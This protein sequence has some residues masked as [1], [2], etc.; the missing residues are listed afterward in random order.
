MGVSGEYILQALEEI[1]AN[2]TKQEL[3][4][5]NKKAKL[6][7]EY[8]E[9]EKFDEQIASVFQNAMKS[10]VLGE[11][12]DFK[13]AEKQSLEIQ[14]KKKEFVEKNSIDLEAIKPLYSCEKC[15]DS[16]YVDGNICDCVRKRAIS[17]SYD[18]LNKDVDLSRYTFEKFDLNMYPDKEIE[19]INSREL[20]T[21]IC[22]F[23]VKY[24]D[25]FDK[26]AESLFFF[27]NTGLGKTHLSL[28]IT[29]V[30]CKKGYN[31]VYGPISKLIGNI[32]KE[33]F[34][35]QDQDNTLESVLNCDLLVLDDL[36]TEFSTQFVVS[37]V[38][39]IINS[40]ILNNKPTIINT[41]LEFDELEQKYSARVVSRISGNY[42]MLKFIGEDIRIK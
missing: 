26:N 36:G 16:G 21:K 34:S 23:C 7:S 13:V 14:Q 18:K 33:H 10:V 39:D 12:F 6:Y 15:S 30:L 32:E 27:G 37:T 24:A 35:N 28:A 8:P 9:L 29:N 42:R 20:M 17:I 3:I 2:G 19:G 22:N 4:A 5:E 25:K 40:R 1:K 38:F 41:N 31:V 11:K